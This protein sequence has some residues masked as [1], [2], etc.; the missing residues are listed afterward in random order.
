MKVSSFYR[1]VSAK[2]E[3]V[4]SPAWGCEAAER[5]V[6]EASHNI[7]LSVIQLEGLQRAER[8]SFLSHLLMPR[9]LSLSKDTS[10]QPHISHLTPVHTQPWLPR[11]ITWMC[12]KFRMFSVYDAANLQGDFSSFC[13]TS[14]VLTRYTIA[15]NYSS[16]DFREQSTLWIY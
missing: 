8:E 5:S 13:G 3:R 11:I 2:V 6:P 1:G 10:Q 16:D 14:A 4:S 15:Q 9:A 7:P 12:G